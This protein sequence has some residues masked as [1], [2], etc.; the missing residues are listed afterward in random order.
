M[1]RKLLQRRALRRKRLQLSKSNV[2]QKEQSLTNTSEITKTEILQDEEAKKAQ[3]TD[4][5]GPG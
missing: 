1:S 5:D 4:Y 3:D 2:F